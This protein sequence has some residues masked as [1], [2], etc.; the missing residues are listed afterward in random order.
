MMNEQKREAVA[1]LQSMLDHVTAYDYAEIDAAVFD[2]GQTFN[3]ADVRDIG[4]AFY[5]G[6]SVGRTKREALSDIRRRLAGHLES[7]QRCSF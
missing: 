6:V 5:N 1:S 4:F 7:I 3:L 2:L